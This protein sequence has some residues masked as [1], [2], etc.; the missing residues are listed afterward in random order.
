MR[1]GCSASAFKKAAKWAHAVALS[2][3]AAVVYVGC[4]GSADGDANIDNRI[5]EGDL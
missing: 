1:L 5:Y 4:G 2:G 3:G